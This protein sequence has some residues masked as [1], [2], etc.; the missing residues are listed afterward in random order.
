MLKAER[1]LNNLEITKISV[2]RFLFHARNTLK[3]FAFPDD[4]VT[5]IG[6]IKSIFY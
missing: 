4:G 3:G 5:A 6:R 1:N 2:K